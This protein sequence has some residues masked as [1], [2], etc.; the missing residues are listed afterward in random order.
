MRQPFQRFPAFYNMFS[1]CD[2]G[3]LHGTQGR[4]LPSKLLEAQSLRTAG[5]INSGPIFEEGELRPR[6]PVLSKGA[7][8][9][10]MLEVF[11]IDRPS[12]R[13]G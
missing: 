1:C 2:W 3:L 12:L 7:T 9:L 4:R 5:D 13:G 8:D 11:P 10:E 6:T